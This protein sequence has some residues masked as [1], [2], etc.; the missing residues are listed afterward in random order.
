[1]GTKDITE[2]LLEEH[3]DVFSDIVNVLLFNGKRRMLEDELEDTPTR[4]QYKADTTK[5]HEQ[6]RDISKFWKKENV[7]IAICGIENQTKMDSDMALR[8]VGYD[9]QSYRS[10]LLKNKNGMNSKE[11]YPVVSMVLYFGSKRWNK[12]KSLHE[13]LN[14]PDY[15]KPFV[16]DYQINVFEIAYLT[17]EQV[18]MFQSDFKFVADYFV[19]M[20][21]NKNYIP[22]SETIK[23]VD[24]VLKMMSVLTEDSRFEEA[25]NNAKG[26]VNSMC[27]VL[28]M[29]EEKGRQE[30]RQE[31]RQMGHQEGINDFAFLISKLISEGRNDD[32][33]L[34]AKNEDARNRFF[35]E[36]G[37]D[38]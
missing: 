22:S 13:R 5:I 6:E 36:F 18:A 24:E 8:I 27:Q 10:Q 2:K 15:L 12:A 7:K 33:K 37:L 31:G 19:Q 3:N 14:I 23:H 35:K 34:A 4:A 26:G 25:Q 16:S 30:G 20:R 29:V 9:G 17:D 21:K 38:I 1:M 28:D 11:R 32:V